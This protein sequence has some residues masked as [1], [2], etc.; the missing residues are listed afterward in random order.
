V[1]VFSQ[2]RVI[3]STVG[4]S[5]TSARAPLTFE[6]EGTLRSFR[7]KNG[8]A[9]LVHG[10]GPRPRSARSAARSAT[11]SRSRSAAPTTAISTA[12]AANP[13]GGRRP[14]SDPLK[15]ARKL[16][17]NT[18][19]SGLAARARPL[20]RPASTDSA[21]GEPQPV[22]A[23]PARQAPQRAGCPAIRRRR[24]P[25]LPLTQSKGQRLVAPTSKTEGG[26]PSQV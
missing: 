9:L 1:A 3:G 16:W 10:A 15:I 4:C 18:R 26:D 14:G 19:L 24:V 11:S 7:R 21:T 5:K 8:G 6:R 23:D 20:P 12:Q 2:D 22:G 13:A 17:K 25:R